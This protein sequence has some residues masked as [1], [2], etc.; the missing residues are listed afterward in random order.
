[1]KKI[2]RKMDEARLTQLLDRFPQIRL[3]AVGDFFLDKYLEL[4]RR[5]KEPSLETGLETYQVTSMRCSPGVAGTVTNNLRALDVGVTALGIIGD[6]GAGY[7]LKRELTVKGVDIGPMV[8]Y[9][10]RVTPTYIKPVMHELDGRVHELNRIDVKNRGPTPNPLEEQII[11]RLRDLA[12]GV[13]GIVV[14]DQVPEPNHGVITDRVRGVL[15]ELG[16]DLAGPAIVVDSRERIGLFRNVILKPNTREAVRADGG[17]D[18]E[19]YEREEA[20]K[21]GAALFEL[22]RRPVLVT[23]GPDGILVFTGGGMQHVPGI[24]VTGSIDIV[25]AGDSVLAGITSALCAGANP[26]EAAFVGNLVASITVQQIGTTGT[27]TRRQVL[28]RFRE[29]F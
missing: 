14:S 11:E 18:K 21:A 7:E 10:D 24:S 22:T 13:D 16:K 20:E 2:G 1:M 28:D 12:P 4:D 5:L 15:A 27:A 6:D 19:E 17:P 8:E 23:V 29:M 9:P 3:L 25:G 26:A